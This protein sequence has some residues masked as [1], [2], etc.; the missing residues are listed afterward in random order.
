MLDSPSHW[1]TFLSTLLFSLCIVTCQ[2]KDSLFL[3]YDHI[4]SDPGKIGKIV[5]IHH[6]RPVQF[7]YVKLPVIRYNLKAATQPKVQSMPVMKHQ[8]LRYE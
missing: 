6:K 1:M 7:K 2:A 3:K 5:P 4:P 8:R